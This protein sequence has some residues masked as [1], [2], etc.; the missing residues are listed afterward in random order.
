MP[1]TFASASALQQHYQGVRAKF[2]PRNPG[3]AHTDY[4]D[5]IRPLPLPPVKLIKAAECHQPRP[6]PAEYD[7]AAI[8]E[9]HAR[10]RATTVYP[11]IRYIQ[12]FVAHAYGLHP[13]DL[14]MKD[15][16]KHKVM[17]RHLAMFF[18]RAFTT[19]SYP[20]IGRAF[21][22]RD[23]TTVLHAVEKFATLAQRL[24]VVIHQRSAARNGQ[25]LDV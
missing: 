21:G 24:G 6:L 22:G 13:N 4:R 20:I 12:A 1:A 10:L 16:T 23:H 15:R 8:L 3:F 14:A 9:L 25:A 11:T 17:P 19:K 2:Y 7:E 18:C 5:R